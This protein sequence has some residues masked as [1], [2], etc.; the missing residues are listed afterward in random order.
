MTEEKYII[1]NLR[2]ACRVLRLLSR[3]G[4]GMP[5]ATIARSLEIPRTSALRILTT[6]HAESMVDQ[7]DR[8]YVL[9]PALIRLGTRA[10]E[11]LDVRT[12]AI[13]VLQE[14]SHE[15]VET[16]HLAVPTGDAALLLEVCDSPHPVR[17][18]SRPGTL[19]DIHCSATGKVFLAH[20]VEDLVRFL[21]GRELV[22]RTPN[23]LTTLEELSAEA[24]R[25]RERGYAIDEQ[26]YREGIRCLAAPIRD[27]LGEVVAAI[28]ITASTTSFTRRRIKAV[29]RTV[30]S[31]AERIS[32]TLGG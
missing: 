4:S 3:E 22:R 6:L 11:N 19:A 21:D 28:G 23:T 7:V 27:A 26:E 13:P 20:R 9:G 2:N 8:S 16:S 32:T 10:L 17:V 12:I 1:P 30:R 24:E 14:L 29:A 5:L 18:A 25:I 31:A 15:T